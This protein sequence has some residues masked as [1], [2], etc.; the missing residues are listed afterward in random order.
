MSNYA[1]AAGQ[2]FSFTRSYDYGI[3]GLN[4]TNV[5]QV[6]GSLAVYSLN[7]QQPAGDYLKFRQRLE[8]KFISL[9]NVLLNGF[10]VN[11]TIKVK[12]IN[13]H[14]QVFIRCTFNNWTTFEDYQAIYVPSEFYSTASQLS[15]TLSSSSISASFCGSNNLNYQP[16]HKDYDTFRFEF[17]LPKTVENFTAHPLSDRNATAS[18]QLCICYRAGAGNESREFWDNNDGKNYEI[19]QYVIDLERLRPNQQVSISSAAA[20]A[21]LQLKNKRSSYYKYENNNKSSYSSS[22]LLTTESG[23]YY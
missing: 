2:F 20:A 19:L 16:V 14:K 10:Q 3:S 21:S 9:E 1:A 12:N 8:Q 17:Q 7:F 5:N 13:F 15:P 11:G 4:Y 23:I 18:I 6:S 22:S